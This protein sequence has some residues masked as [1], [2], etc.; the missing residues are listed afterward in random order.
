MLE[1]GSPAAKVTLRLYARNL[2][3]DGRSGSA[4]QVRVELTGIDTWGIGTY[5]PEVMIAGHDV[6]AIP[7][8]DDDIRLLKGRS[9]DPLLIMDI[10]D[11]LYLPLQWT[12]TS[13]LKSYVDV[14]TVYTGTGANDVKISDLKPY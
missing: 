10:G 5:A 9:L 13:I 7:I 11:K 2:T 3:Q 12:R 1:E 4:G 8:T 14:I 6:P